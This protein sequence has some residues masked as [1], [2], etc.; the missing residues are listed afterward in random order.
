MA[1]KVDLLPRLRSVAIHILQRHLQKHLL[2][3]FGAMRLVPTTTTSGVAI[4]C[5]TTNQPLPYL[6]IATVHSVATG[7]F[8][9]NGKVIQW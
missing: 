2:P 3:R 4:C 6:L 8:I 5:I 1:I 7:V 9:Y